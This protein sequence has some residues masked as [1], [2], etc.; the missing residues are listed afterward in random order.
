M[1]KLF[2]FK[3]ILL[4]LFVATI[5]VAG[6]GQTTVTLGGEVTIVCPATPT[7][8]YT[9]PPAGITFSNLTR[10]S[11]V[12]CASASDGLS[13][14]GFNTASAAAS[15][16]ANK[17]YTL[18]IT[19]DATHTFTLTGITWLTTLS[20]TAA[21]TQFTIQYQNNGGAVTT[22]GTANQT[23]TTSNTFSGSVVVAAGTSLIIYAIP[24]N[25]SAATGTVRYRNGS[26]FDLTASTVNTNPTVNL[27][28]SSN[29]GTEAAATIIT[30]TATAS[31]AVTGNQTVSLGVSGTN[32]TSGDYN[33]SNT[34]ITI[35]NGATTGTVTFTVVDDPLVEGPE[36]AILT[37]S[38]PSSGIVLGSTTTQNISIADN[39]IPT[40]S[41]TAGSNAAEPSTNGSFNITLSNPAP[42]GGVIIAYTLSGSSTLNSDYSDPLSGSITIPLGNTSGTITL[43]VN[44]DPNYE[45]TETINILLNSASNGFA[46][47]NSTASINLLDNDPPPPIVINEVYGGG[48]NTGAI[49]RNDFIELYNP[50]NSAV[51]L[52][53]W[54]VQYAS[55]AGTSWQKTDLTGSIPAHGYYLI[56]EAV[57]TGGTTNLPTPDAIGT[58]A[59]AATAGKV[60]LVS[61]SVALSGACPVIGVVDFAGYGTTANCFEG[62][63]PTPAPSNPTSVQRNPIGFDS[64]NNNTDFIVLT[65][66]TPKNSVVD[67]TPPVIVSL[68]PVDNATGVMTSFIATITFNENILKGTGTV[69]LKKVS[70][71]SIVRTID[72]T[73]ADISTSGPS[74]IFGINSLAFNTAYYFEINAGAFKDAD[75][76]IF[77]GL[78]GTTAWNFTTAATPPSGILGIT[79][80]FNICSGNLPD[81]FTQY[82]ILGPQIWGCTTFGRNAADLP[83]G[84]A[85]NGLQI[86]GFSG[87]NIP[88][89]DWLISPSFNLTGTS[90]PLL[91]FWSRTAF[92]GAALQ[93]KVSTDYTGTGDP[94][95]ATWSDI[96]G[97]FP[98][99]VSDIWKLSE[100]INLSGYKSPHTYFAFIYNS[101]S[102]DG[103]RWTLDD[104]TVI[105]SLVPPPPSLTISVT[106][107]QYNL[108][109]TAPRPIRPLHLLAMILPVV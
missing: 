62:A 25:A 35:L 76:N 54:S 60:A 28:V 95:L 45:G 68:F 80:N 33:L 4:L 91:S 81:G 21:G 7:A 3:T 8:T 92:T 19:A 77:A 88:N 67:V 102:E 12:T 48:G 59:M 98:A 14:S 61:N 31:P 13:G 43:N 24:S 55:A 107:I 74:A 40:V 79:Y 86:N 9:T 93:L 66:P 5:N 44:D 70:D 104:I 10:G 109:P 2:T 49:F 56:Q 37:I 22:F 47:A 75:D 83:S 18:T 82:N 78:S 57:G 46:I 11:G 41:V 23:G 69:T 53:G 36:T 15:F 101:S 51:S 42:A 105:N 84:S 65:L 85:P 38:N 90:F 100:N 108:L 16:A 96:N 64:Q 26:T 89:E 73:T 72:V 106:D 87:V 94:N 58:I 39:D 50:N 1:R 30:V 103:A 29:S 97:K 63:G 71:N 34:T 6:F 32:I 17:Y 99:Q 27:S 52:T 20:G